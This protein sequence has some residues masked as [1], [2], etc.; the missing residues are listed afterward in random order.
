[1]HVEVFIGQYP[2]MHELGLFI[3][4]V[5]D[6]LLNRPFDIYYQEMYCF[7]SWHPFWQCYGP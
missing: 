4:N 7:D 3:K 1:M 6:T 5:H 2:M